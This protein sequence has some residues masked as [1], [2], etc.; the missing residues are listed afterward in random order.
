V[1]KVKLNYKTFV[2]KEEF[3][4][5]KGQQGPEPDIMTVDEGVMTV[6]E[7]VTSTTDNARPNAT[8]VVV[9]EM[10][11]LLLIMLMMMM[12]LMMMILYLLS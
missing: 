7:G 10:I 3:K 12:L 6:D 1:R 8:V 5:I 11:L 4:A 9:V 2:E